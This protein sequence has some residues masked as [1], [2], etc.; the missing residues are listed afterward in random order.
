LRS[1][2]PSL[3][4]TRCAS[5]LSFDRLSVTA[6]RACHPAQSVARLAATVVEDGPRPITLYRL[7]AE[8][9]HEVER[10]VRTPVKAPPIDSE[11]FLRMRAASFVAPEAIL[12]GLRGLRPELT[13]RLAAVD[14]R[15]AEF[16]RRGEPALFQLLELV[17]F[18]SVLEAHLRWLGRTEKALAREAR[19]AEQ[20]P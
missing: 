3:A 6:F 12:L 14:A 17:L 9:R 10:W 2:M 16:A 7:T 20:S 5:M 4:S 18:R 11:V 13:G 19:A 1:R 8:G 15:E